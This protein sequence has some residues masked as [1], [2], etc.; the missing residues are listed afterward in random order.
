MWFLG[1]LQDRGS[2]YARQLYTEQL[3]LAESADQAIAPG[4]GRRGDHS[5]LTSQGFWELRARQLASGVEPLC[6]RN[7]RK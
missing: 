5:P 6:T 7:V 1:L 3:S 4:F 2:I